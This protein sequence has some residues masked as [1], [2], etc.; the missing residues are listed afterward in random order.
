MPRQCGDRG[1]SIDFRHVIG[2]LVRKPGAFAQYKW[3]EQMFPSWT[4]RSAYD[5][6]T[7]NEPLKA[8]LHYLEVLEVAAME[9]VS[10]VETALEDLMAQPRGVISA[11]EVK[12]MLETYRD[13]ALRWRQAP[14]PEVTLEQYDA[15]L[16]SEEE[17]E[18]VSHG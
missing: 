8:D 15:L 13:E 9:G 18:V 3:R 2:W 5:S 14:P 1:A 16:G 6:L 11:G 4:F 17:L 10:A 7:R 12:A